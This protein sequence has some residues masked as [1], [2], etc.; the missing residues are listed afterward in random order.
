MAAEDTAHETS[1]AVWDVPATVAAGERFTV[2]LGA[3]SSAGCGLAGRT[4]AV[5]DTADAVVATASL[6][7]A[8]WPDTDALFWAEL[9]LQAP[10]EPGR[11]AL[12][13]Q[14][15]AVGLDEPHQAAS[16]Q[17][18]V[19]IVPAAAHK[20]AV[21]IM[22]AGTPVGSAYLRLGP[23]RAVTDDAGRADVRLAPGRYQLQVWKAGYDIPDLDL[24]IATDTA[25]NVEALPQPEP[26]LD[27]HWTA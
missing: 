9:E 11:V 4:V 6:G 7:D 18:E 17:F 22:A 12:T 16:S 3:R 10:N 24:D 5:W 13:A 1:L 23:Y 25:V 20:L 2:K 15:D 8:P 26:D 14:F 27:A 19:T 21:T